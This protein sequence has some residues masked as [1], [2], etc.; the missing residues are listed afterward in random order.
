MLRRAR[1]DVAA[2]IARRNRVNDIGFFG[3]QAY[4]AEMRTYR[5]AH[6]LQDAV[7][8]LDPWSDRPER[9]DSR[10]FCALRRKDRSA[11]SM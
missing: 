7:V 10:W 6:I 3:R 2:R 9:Q 4:Y 5:N 8:L 11:E 1:R